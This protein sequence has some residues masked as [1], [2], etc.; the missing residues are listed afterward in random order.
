MY[1]E[2]PGYQIQKEL[3]SGGMSR[4]YL[5]VKENLPRKFA[6]KIIDPNLADD[7]SFIARFQR[8]ARTTSTIDDPNIVGVIDHGRVGDMYYIIMEYVEGIDLQKAIRKH[9]PPQEIAL[10]IIQEIARALRAAHENSIIH[11]DIK[12]AN[13]LLGFK[14]QVKVVDFGLA[15][16]FN[17]TGLQLTL[18]S[19]RMGTPA[20]MSPE[21]DMARTTDHRTDI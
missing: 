5:A 12:P 13:V 18:P 21:Q 17:S 7:P 11:R 6:I 9:V 1:P 4:V 20:F 2:I 15:R 10:L 8:E 3:G 14:G 19:V 16:D